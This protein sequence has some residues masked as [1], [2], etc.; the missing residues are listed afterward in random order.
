MRVLDFLCPRVG[1]ACVLEQ[2]NTLLFSDDR[3]VPLTFGGELWEYIGAGIHGG[4]FIIL[5]V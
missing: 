5:M 1:T 4:F 3:A 2:S